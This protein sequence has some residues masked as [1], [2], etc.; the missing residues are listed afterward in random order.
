MVPYETSLKKAVPLVFV[1]AFLLRAFHLNLPLLE[2]YNNVTRQTVSAMIAR[3]FYFHGFHFWYPELDQG[4]G[5][6]LFNAEMP[7]GPFLAA[8]L[9]ALTGG[10]H[11]WAARL[12]SVVFS[13]I[14]IGFLYGF[15]KKTEGQTAALFAAGF[16][17]ISPMGL[18]LGRAVQPDMMMLTGSAG[19]L[20]Y[21]YRYFKEKKM[22]F[23]VF[24]VLWTFLAVASKTYTL[25][26]FLPLAA[27]AWIYQN[28]RAFTDG[29]NYL[30]VFIV[31]LTLIWY[32][33]MWHQGKIQTLYYDTIRYNRGVDYGSM[34]DLFSLANL[35]L[36]FKIF[37]IHILTPAGTFFFLIG[38]VAGIR[39]KEDGIFYAWLAAV[40]LFLLITWRIVMRNP[41][42]ELALYPPAAVFVG[43]GAALLLDW[44]G[45]VLRRHRVIF[46]VALTVV[47]IPSVLYFYR[48][49]YFLPE[50]RKSILIA[51]QAARRIT[52][53]KDLIIASYEGGPG[54]LY[55]CERKGWELDLSGAGEDPVIKLER[56]RAQGAAYFVTI[57]QNLS[58][59]TPGFEQ[60]L[61][62]HYSLV[63]EN[64]DAVIYRLQRGAS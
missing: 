55:Y 61:K 27:I 24:S 53:E 30:Y 2:P 23:Y 22:R 5:P 19:G 25:Y 47:V 7:F 45:G 62:Q 37:F 20:Y 10:V 9:Y 48:G 34:S 43:R 63:I 15:V 57:P 35:K 44:K 21:F 17:A 39:K 8:I 26:M 40:A 51:G 13:M 4:A 14:L 36:F 38:C 46:G 58:R 60:F 33:W 3:N 12:V 32:A 31:S 28:K 18:A 16:A 29:R 6:Y 50:D 11:E 56:L 52:D 59:A 54:L 49:L 1:G 64:T 42:Y 41:Y